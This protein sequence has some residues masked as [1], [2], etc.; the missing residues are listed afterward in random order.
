MQSLY[1][2]WRNSGKNGD[3]IVLDEQINKRVM[4]CLIE[5][6]KHIHHSPPSP[7]ASSHP[8]G[9]IREIKFAL[10]SEQ[11]VAGDEQHRLSLHG[12]N[13]ISPEHRLFSLAALLCSWCCFCACHPP[14]TR[15]LCARPVGGGPVRRLLYCAGLSSFPAAWRLGRATRSFDFLLENFRRPVSLQDV[16]MRA[17]M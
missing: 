12:V 5:A 3:T 11:F 15:R 7:S 16:Y 2:G 6:W 10:L 14:P 9:C 4:A 1:Q 13:P 8:A 17:F